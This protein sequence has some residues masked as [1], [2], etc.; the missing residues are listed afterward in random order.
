MG[1]VGTLVGASVGAGLS[2]SVGTSVG[3][4]VGASVGTAVGA[5]VGFALGAK[6]ATHEVRLPKIVTKPS[7]QGQEYVS[8]LL[9]SAQYVDDRSQSCELPL[10]T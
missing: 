6:V 8:P 5:A 1:T 10:H 4:P 9:S 2:A 3:A 7:R